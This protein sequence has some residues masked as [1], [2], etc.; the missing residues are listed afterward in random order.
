MTELFSET[1]MKIK[2]PV[3]IVFLIIGTSASAETLRCGSKIVDIGMNMDEVRK[4]CGKPSS[5]AIEEQDVRSGNRVVGKTQL[6]TW[7]YKR[8][9]GQKTAVLQFDQDNLMSI[10]YISK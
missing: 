9:S 5:T 4:Y 2:I 7:H 6:T 3:L 10:S 8:S 1:D